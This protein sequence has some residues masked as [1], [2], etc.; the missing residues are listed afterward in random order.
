MYNVVTTFA[1]KIA[2]MIR[3]QSTC[4]ATALNYYLETYDFRVT[5]CLI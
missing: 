5:I 4:Q 2:K 1:V 3:H